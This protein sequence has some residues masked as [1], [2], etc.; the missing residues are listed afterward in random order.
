MK[1]APSTGWGVEQSGVVWTVS[2]DVEAPL[3]DLTDAVTLATQQVGTIRPR[4]D[5]PTLPAS[6]SKIKKLYQDDTI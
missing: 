2:Q 3:V 4:E 1:L 5:L 6:W